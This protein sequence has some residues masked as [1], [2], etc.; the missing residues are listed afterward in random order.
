VVLTDCV[1]DGTFTSL[2]LTGPT[3]VGPVGSCRGRA[4]TARPLRVVDVGASQKAAV[5]DAAHHREQCAA[6][7][8]QR[9]GRAEDVPGPASTPRSRSRRAIAAPWAATVS[10][11]TASKRS[12]TAGCRAGVAEMPGVITAAPTLEEAKSM[13]RD[14]LREYLASYRSDPVATPPGAETEAI[15][16]TFAT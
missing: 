14:A 16:L 7:R 13:I 6:H 9:D 15:R 12:R 1:V 5:E 3:A 4:S 11:R 2:A 8:H 10:A